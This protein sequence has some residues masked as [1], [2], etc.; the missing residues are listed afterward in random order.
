[1]VCFGAIV[2]EPS[3]QKTFYARVRPITDRYL[4]E[5]LLHFETLG[6]KMPALM[7]IRTQPSTIRGF[8]CH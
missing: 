3:L 5:A 7:V 6:L 4:E 1:M 8:G 2:V